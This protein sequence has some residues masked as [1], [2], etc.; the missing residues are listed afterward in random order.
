VTYDRALR[1]HG[2]ERGHSGRRCGFTRRTKTT[3]VPEIKQDKKKAGKRRFFYSLSGSSGGV[4]TKNEQTRKKKYSF[5]RKK[6][7]EG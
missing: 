1:F 5:E 4:F 2:R 6:K 7:I 3:R